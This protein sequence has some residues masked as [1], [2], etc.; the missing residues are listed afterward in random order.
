MIEMLACASTSKLRRSGMKGIVVSDQIDYADHPLD[1]TE[2]SS[3]AELCQKH[4]MTLLRSGSKHYGQYVSITCRHE[5]GSESST[6]WDSREQ[7]GGN[8]AVARIR[9]LSRELS[10]HGGSHA[11]NSHAG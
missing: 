11:A 3:L 5:N 4:D 8:S 10:R 7:G 1:S 6:A 2:R 9:E